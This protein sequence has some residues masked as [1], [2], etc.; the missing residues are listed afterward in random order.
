MKKP[1]FTILLATLSSYLFA[2][3]GTLIFANLG[4]GVDAPVTNWNGTPLAGSMFAADLWWAPGIVTDPN[5]LVE[6]QQPAVFYS[7]GYFLGGTRKIPGTSS[8]TVITVQV[9]VFGGAPGCPPFCWDCYCPTF[10]QGESD[11][12]PLSLAAPPAPPGGLTGLS[13][14]GL[15]P[16]TTY[17][18]PQFI[19]NTIAGTKLVLG[20]QPSRVASNFVVQQNA[21]L[22]TTNWVTLT[23]RPVLVGPQFQIEIPKPT[24]TMFYRLVSQ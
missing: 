23:Q 24:G 17:S 11:L 21:D 4:S 8:G 16:P 12:I 13:S 2:Q 15:S 5:M 9:R 3:E 22:T 20:W 1:F 14:F 19:L 7:D 18:A 6:L 10:Q